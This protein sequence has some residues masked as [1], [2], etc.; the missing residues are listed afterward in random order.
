MIRSTPSRAPLLSNRF[1]M[2]GRS[3]LFPR[4]RLFEDR[5][6][7]GGWHWQGRFSRTIALADVRDVEWWTGAPDCNLEVRLASGERLGLWLP[8]AAHWKFAIA[9]RV[10]LPVLHQQT[11]PEVPAASLAA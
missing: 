4:A 7:L 11:L 9:E 3:L 2:L 6:E 10:G 5:I 1:S 8:D